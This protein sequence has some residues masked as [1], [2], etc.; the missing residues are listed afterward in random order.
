MGGVLS[1]GQEIRIRYL[2]AT[3]ERGTGKGLGIRRC[4]RVRLK[5][6]AVCAYDSLRSGARFLSLMQRVGL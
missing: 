5:M 6:M 4:N 3:Y 1:Q 2:P